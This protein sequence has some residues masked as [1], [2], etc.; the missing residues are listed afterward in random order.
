MPRRE[1]TSS[2]QT[3]LKNLVSNIKRQ[4]AG[5]AQ[6]LVDLHDSGLW[7][8]THDTWGA[9]CV[10]VLGQTRQ[11][12]NRRIKNI[13][14]I[15]M[16]DEGDTEPMGSALSERAT[17][18]VS[19]LPDDTAVEVLR[20]ATKTAPKTESGKPK[21]TANHVA[22]TREKYVPAKRPNR[23]SGKAATRHDQFKPLLESVG[24]LARL[25]SSLK[26]D[27]GEHAVGDAIYFEMNG[28]AEWIEAWKKKKAT[29][30][31][32]KLRVSR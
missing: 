19:S 28:I 20:E 32:G 29:V 23:K 24:V 1:L 13:R 22:E 12:V 8:A 10:D 4:L 6:D 30:E 26:S 14:L 16:V 11:A 17:R 2:Q 25:L 18:E 5:A 31:G 3:R 27:L 9:F 7:S 15:T 21:V